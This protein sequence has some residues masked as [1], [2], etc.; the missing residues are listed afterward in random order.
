MK[1]NP[2]FWL[3]FVGFAVYD[4]NICLC[5]WDSSKQ[6]TTPSTLEPSSTL[7]H[8]ST[9]VWKPNSSTF[10]VQQF[11]VTFVQR[12][13]WRLNMYLQLRICKNSVSQKIH[14][15]RCNNGD[16]LTQDLHRMTFE[17]VTLKYYTTLCRDL[18]KCFYGLSA[19]RIDHKLLECANKLLF[20]V[21]SITISGINSK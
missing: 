13:K 11:F 3:I 8:A 1:N 15:V 16:S 20:K 6:T 5:L 2:K 18:E 21:T 7:Y 9:S 4:C 17:E 19:D 14:A 12:Q 10:G